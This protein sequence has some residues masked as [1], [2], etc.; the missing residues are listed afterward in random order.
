[1][2]ELGYLFMETITAPHIYVSIV[3]VLKSIMAA[4]LI[5]IIGY[6]IAK[7]LC[8]TTKKILYK[9]G[10]D[11]YFIDHNLDYAIG[12]VSP[13]TVMSEIVKWYVWV[14]FLIPAISIL[15]LGEISVLLMDF[16][17]WIPSLLVGITI[18][19]CGLIVSEFVAVKVRT[20]K[21]KL[22]NH[23]ALV[24]KAIVLFFFLDVA[25]VEIGLNIA[26]VENTFLILLSG[27][28]ITMSLAIGIGLGFALKE[29]GKNLID[30]IKK[31]IDRIEA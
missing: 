6:V 24:L 7:I 2:A 19:V 29:D 16:V 28:V 9:V 14:L 27:V 20:L 11:K 12:K 26:L 5:V 15:N 30:S 21:F 25:I 31:D 18:V 10:L 17:K 13:S 3:Y 1:M 22:I 4:A 23:V 8:I